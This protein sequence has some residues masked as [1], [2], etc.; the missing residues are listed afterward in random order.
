MTSNRKGVLPVALIA[1]AGL[2]G[3]AAAADSG[4]ATA[5]GRT[6]TTALISR[7]V[8]G[9]LPN[10]SSTNAVISG[11]R[12]YAR[13]IAFQSDASNLVHGD[14]NR[15]RDVFAVK[16]T[17]SID[18]L[19][20]RWSGGRAILVSRTRSGGSANGPSYGAAVSGGFRN[21]GRCVAFVSRASNLVS[22]DT[23]GRADAFLVSSP[24]RA[25]RR[26]SPGGGRQLKA[27][28]SS[29]TVSGD[30]SRVSFTAGGRLYTKV[31]GQRA[32]RIRARGTAS[33]P[34]YATGHS[35]ALVYAARGGVWLSGNGTRR[36]RLVARGGRNPAFNDLKRRTLAYEKTIRGTT[37][38]GY[39]DL[40]RGE[41]IISSRRGALGNGHSRKPVMGNSGYYAMFESDASN[42][43][44]NANGSTGDGNGRAD[45]YL[46]TDVRDITLVQSVREKAVPLPGGGYNPSMSY[47]ANYIVFDTPAPL[48]S[49]GGGHHGHQIYMRYLGGI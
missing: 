23:N 48:D 28:V 18:N 26:M 32:R 8:D 36:G 13:V 1:L 10:G 34:S 15:Q 11:D 41:R 33:D 30:C 5:A 35:D 42:L 25:P 39:R 21:A 2:S 43:G 6:Q 7:S 14:G 24:G 29:V 17:G 31:L 22:R 44:V 45:S 12:R 4:D 37:Q 47:Y 9:G 16:R 46:F 20:T 49:R 3:A 40:G 19:G 38:I 27:D